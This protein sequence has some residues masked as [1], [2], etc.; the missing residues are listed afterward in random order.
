[1]PLLVL[2][3]TIELDQLQDSSGCKNLN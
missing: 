2:Y 3:G 1:L